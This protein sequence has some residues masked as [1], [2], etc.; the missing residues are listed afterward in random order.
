[1]QNTVIYN[2]GHAAQHHQTFHFSGERFVWKVSADQNTV[3]TACFYPKGSVTVMDG[4][5]STCTAWMWWQGSERISGPITGGLEA[6][7]CSPVCDLLRH[8]QLPEHL[9]E[10]L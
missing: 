8:E 4:R 1:M 10:L 9:E 3:I 2:F 5:V 6:S 7:H